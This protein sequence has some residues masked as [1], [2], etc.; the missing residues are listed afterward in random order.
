MR[1]YLEE[2]ISPL[3]DVSIDAPEEIRM[4]AVERDRKDTEV[5]TGEQSYMMRYQEARALNKQY[6]TYSEDIK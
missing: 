4:Q 6:K 5:T 2:Y 3:K 1:D